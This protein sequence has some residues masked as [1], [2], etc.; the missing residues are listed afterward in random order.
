MVSIP[1][2]SRGK[3]PR[4]L[5]EYVLVQ[6]PPQHPQSSVVGFDVS[7]MFTST[8]KSEFRMRNG[9]TSY[10]FPNLQPLV[11]GSLLLL[12][13]LVLVENT[14]AKLDFRH[15]SNAE[16]QKYLASVNKKYP[17]ITKL[18][19]IGNSIQDTPLLVLIISE[20]VHQHIT[21]KP[22]VK[23]IGNI[24]GNEVV[25]RELLLHLIDYLVTNYRRNSTVTRILQTSV[26]HILPTIN[27]DG[28]AVAKQ[29][30]CNGSAGRYN[31][32]YS[33][34]NRDFKD[35]PS[36]PNIQPETRAIMD[37]I[38]SNTFALSA[39]LH[40]GAVVVNYPFDYRKGY[41]HGPAYFTSPDDDVFV[42]LALNYSRSHYDMHQSINCSQKEYFKDGITNGAAWY[43][44]EGG[45]QDYNYYHGVMELTLEL[46]CCKYPTA[47]TLPA[48]WAKNKRAII[49]FLKLV[50]MGV[51]GLVVDERRR[52]IM[53]ARLS[54]GDR[55][56]SFRSSRYGE[57]WRLLLPGRYV[58]KVKARGFRDY[59]S[60]PFQVRSGRVHRLDVVMT[61]RN[62]LT[63][64]RTKLRKT[65]G[66][67]R[68]VTTHNVIGM[69]RTTRPMQTTRRHGYGV[70][71]KSNE[72]KH[73][74][75][76]ILQVTNLSLYALQWAI[77]FTFKHSL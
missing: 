27:P 69:R 36:S 52:P 19:S 60:P 13:M 47:A 17:H 21:L 9:L 28:Y 64:D 72:D 6:P 54:I 50:H 67:L 3:H 31:T 37:W 43:P 26:V 22:H 45:M 16:L 77:I 12:V 57:Y 18:H 63:T 15:H 29:G 73:S 5:P 33:D 25:G 35:N 14:A 75:A 7:W 8:E 48:F 59:L 30:D 34:L 39:S 61:R 49:N 40:G 4:S 71:A 51:K 23:Y 58:L 20:S 24:H 41:S 62:S 32:L 10:C 1:V 38:R 53:K 42:Y 56:I 70:I 11:T 55:Y 74:K 68:E 46:S 44:V 2:V 66:L 65:T 76:H